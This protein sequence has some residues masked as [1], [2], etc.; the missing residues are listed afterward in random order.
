MSVIYFLCA[1]RLDLCWRA[2]RAI[3]LSEEASGF[4]CGAVSGPSDTQHEKQAK[5]RLRVGSHP[6]AVVAGFEKAG[7]WL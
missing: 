5:A 3:R 2:G 1:W 4:G 7:A 6:L